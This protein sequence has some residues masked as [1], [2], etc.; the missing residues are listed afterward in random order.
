MTSAREGKILAPVI[1]LQQQREKSTQ[2]LGFWPEHALDAL[3]LKAERL[4]AMGCGVKLNL[5][6]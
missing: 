6:V 1:F 4:A 3:T 5:R 2:S